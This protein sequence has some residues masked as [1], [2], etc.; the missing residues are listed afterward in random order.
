MI[1]ADRHSIGQLRPGTRVRFLRTDPERAAEILRRKL[2]LWRAL[3]PGLH[4]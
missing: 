3:V 4:L 1:R 2:M